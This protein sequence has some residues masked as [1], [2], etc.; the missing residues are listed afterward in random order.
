MPLHTFVSAA[1]RCVVSARHSYPCCHCHA[2]ATHAHSGCRSAFGQTCLDSQTAAWRAA[3]GAG[4][5]ATAGTLAGSQHANQS[6]RRTGQCCNEDPASSRSALH[7]SPPSGLIT[8]QGPAHLRPAGQ[9]PQRRQCRRQ[10]RPRNWRSRSLHATAHSQ[11]SRAPAQRVSCMHQQ[12]VRTQWACR[13]ARAVHPAPTRACQGRDAHSSGCPPHLCPT[14][15][16]TPA[17]APCSL[18]DT[19]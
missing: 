14:G 9:P 13:A 6:T 3:A 7:C 18:G 2:T 8:M 4:A 12:L 15:A 19:L 5:A 16:C 1:S 17:H 11:T 10:W